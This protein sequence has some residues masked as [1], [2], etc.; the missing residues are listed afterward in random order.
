M[1]AFVWRHL[2]SLSLLFRVAAIRVGQEKDDMEGLHNATYDGY[3]LP[4]PCN[5]MSNF[6]Q[7]LNGEENCCVC[8]PHSGSAYFDEIDQQIETG[9][10]YDDDGTQMNKM[11]CPAWAVDCEPGDYAYEKGLREDVPL[12]D[13]LTCDDN[14]CADVAKLHRAAKGELNKYA[15]TAAPGASLSL[16]DMYVTGLSNSQSSGRKYKINEC[17]KC[18]CGE[19][20]EGGA[21][22][23]KALR[24]SLWCPSKERD[25]CTS[26]DDC[27]ANDPWPRKVNQERR[28]ARAKA[29]IAQDAH[30]SDRHAAQDDV[31]SSADLL[32]VCRSECIAKRTK[33]WMAALK[34]NKRQLQDKQRY[35]D[36]LYFYVQKKDEQSKA[37][38]DYFN[39][40]IEEKWIPPAR[41]EQVM[42]VTNWQIN[43][44][45]KGPEDLCA[46]HWE[47]CVCMMADPAPADVER[48]IIAD[49]CLAPG[50]AHMKCSDYKT[51][52]GGNACK[53]VDKGRCGKNCHECS[54]DTDFYANR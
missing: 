16:I 20:V 47:C 54:G 11:L 53:A 19:L 38:L 27:D 18:A 33:E 2:Y 13:Q 21:L 22:R 4:R 28:R 31:L 9:P 50:Y 42:T 12:I 6:K 1:S 30:A 37:D 41:K 49:F 3:P 52:S 34:R 17:S 29:K 23:C 44:G 40:Q 32:T 26:L 48:R 43:N 14:E 24:T 35:F 10:W 46:P 25:C 39:Q 36:F 15:D 51:A 7:R 5:G 45:R 8:D